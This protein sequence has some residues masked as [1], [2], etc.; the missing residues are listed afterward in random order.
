MER[1]DSIPIGLVVGISDGARGGR[2]FGSMFR[3]G[4]EKRL[5]EFVHPFVFGGPSA[6]SS[7]EEFVLFEQLRQNGARLIIGRSLLP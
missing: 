1:A 3:R 5:A 7:V 2:S 4:F 6:G